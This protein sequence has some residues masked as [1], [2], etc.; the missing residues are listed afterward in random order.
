MGII[1]PRAGECA[2]GRY[3]SDSVLP[4]RSYIDSDLED[5][6]LGSPL[7]NSVGYIIM[8]VRSEMFFYKPVHIVLVKLLF[9][10]YR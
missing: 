10:V 1:W 8:S 5:G 3:A 7:D 6:G 9:N 2:T 4:D